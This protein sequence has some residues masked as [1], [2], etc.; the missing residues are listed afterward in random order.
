ME[1]FAGIDTFKDCY[2]EFGNLLL[3]LSVGAYTWWL[4]YLINYP[5][6]DFLLTLL[7]KVGVARDKTT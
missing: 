7:S 6:V 1:Y 2:Q 4:G 3:N 5:G